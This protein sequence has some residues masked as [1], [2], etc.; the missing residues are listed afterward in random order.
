[1]KVK[2]TIEPGA[3]AK[4]LTVLD[5][6]V[7]DKSALPLLGDVLLT[8]DKERDE[9]ALTGSDGESWLTL[10]CVTVTTDDEGGIVRTRYINLIEPDQKDPLTAVCIPFR[11][12]K[13]A[14]ACLPKALMLQVWLEAPAAN[15]A[16]KMRMNYGIGELQMPYDSALE[17][18]TAIDINEDALRCR[19]AIDC[20]VLLPAMKMARVCCANDELRPVMNTECIDVFHDHLV[21]VASDGHA[22]TRRQFDLGMGYLQQSNFP[23][24]DPQTGNALSAKLLVPKN[25]LSIIDQ[26]FSASATVT[27]ASDFQRVSFTAEGVRLVARMIDGNYPNY[28][29]VIPKDNNHTVILAVASLQG[30]LRRL[31]LSANESSNMVTVT[32]QQNELILEAAD[33]DLSRSGNERVAIQ[34]AIDCS[35]PD[36]Y[37]VGFKI[38][39]LATLLGC[40]P[41]ENCYLLLSEPNV[42]VLMK[43][44]DAKQN[45]TLLLSP[46]IINQ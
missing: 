9:F 27:I 7:Q 34:N 40:V 15:E 29:S 43:P 3:F 1:M 13:E 42:S 10:D 20:G 2:L 33:Y 23:A 26:A 8:Y 16:G 24:I 6:I 46:M 30:A 21:I 22:M 18:P 44:E 4:A 17:Y 41:T 12:L 37:Q 45:L 19:F 38:S 36:G 32:R 5:K 14:V 39:T 11:Q 25:V 28:E 35:L 31:R